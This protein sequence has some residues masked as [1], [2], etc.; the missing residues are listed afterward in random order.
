MEYTIIEAPFGLRPQVQ[1]PSPLFLQEMTEEG[2]RQMVSDHYDCLRQSSIANLFPRTD[3]AFEKAKLRSSDFFIQICGGHPYFNENRGA[4]MMA[5]RHQPFKITADGRKV[6]LNCYINVLRKL[7]IS[8]E[9]L[10]SFWHYINIF[11][12]WM[13]NT[14]EK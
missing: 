4:P 9:A 10:T 1:L 3:N 12:L 5:R 7:P 11:S 2:I 8:E 13:V 6:W 14:E